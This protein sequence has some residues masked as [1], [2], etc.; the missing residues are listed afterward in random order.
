MNNTEKNK[1]KILAGGICTTRGHGGTK[2]HQLGARECH[3]VVG[4]GCSRQQL[5]QDVQVIFLEQRH[6]V[7][8]ILHFS[9]RRK[10]SNEKMSDVGRNVQERRCGCDSV[11]RTRDWLYGWL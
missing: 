10:A 11:G 7:D 9:L 3:A 8:D 6:I 5:C 1:H 2:C 4:D